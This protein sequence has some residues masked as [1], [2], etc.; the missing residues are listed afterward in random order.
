MTNEDTENKFILTSTFQERTVSN[1]GNVGKRVNFSH[2]LK[3]RV[4]DTHA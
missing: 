1:T 3:G 4:S 2:E